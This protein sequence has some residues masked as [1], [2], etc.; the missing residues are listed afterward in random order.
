[1]AAAR[2]AAAGGRVRE[3]ALVAQLKGMVPRSALAEQ[4]G[5]ATS[6]AVEAAAARG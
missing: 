4:R 3:A 5:Q 1:V 6:L 2:E